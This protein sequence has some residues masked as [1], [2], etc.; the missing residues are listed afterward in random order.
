MAGI[1][2]RKRVLIVGEVAAR[3][4]AARKGEP[5]RLEHA[6]AHVGAVQQLWKCPLSDEGY[7][8]ERAWERA[9][10]GC[11][12]LHPEG[13]CGLQRLGTYCRVSPPGARVPRWWCPAAGV[14]ISL[15]PSFLAARFSG[16]LAEVEDV[17]TAVEDAGGVS[18][19]VDV[20]HPPDAEDAI[21]LPSA[22]RS[23]RRRVATVRAALLAIVTLMP[24][25]FSGV[26]PTLRA[27]RAALGRDRVLVVLR[28]ICERHL[29]ALTA[30]LGFYA[31]G[32]G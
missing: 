30:P 13:G 19:A 1:G 11:C 10:L 4:G 17:V 12:P 31:R 24:E 8:T 6:R 18:G 23:I 26:A 2:E 16:T 28:E 22:L 27:M 21:T 5:A 32:P 20:V 29:R 25:R 7:V 15:L 14:S 9:T 3:S